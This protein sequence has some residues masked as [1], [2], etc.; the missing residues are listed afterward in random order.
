VCARRVHVRACARVCACECTCVH[1][2]ACAR[3]CARACVRACAPER[4]CVCVCVCTSADARAYVDCTHQPGRCGT[5]LH[6]VALRSLTI[7]S[8][9]NRWK[10]GSIELVIWCKVL[11]LQ[12]HAHG[13]KVTTSICLGLCSLCT[14]A[15][16]YSFWS[17]RAK[18]LAIGTGCSL[19]CS[20]ASF[21][22]CWCMKYGPCSYR[23]IHEHMCLLPKCAIV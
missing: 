4:V 12:L 17:R 23:C 15:S 2:R 21:S 13:L 14:A 19:S 6:F 3:A 11:A 8:M 16:C 7:F 20:S 1:M 9:S 5:G 10:V 18:S 22:L